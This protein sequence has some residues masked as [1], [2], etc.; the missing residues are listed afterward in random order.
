[1]NDL[2]LEK[3]TKGMFDGEAPGQIGWSN[4]LQQ[5]RHHLVNRQP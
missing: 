5:K 4:E 3:S 2:D 1:M